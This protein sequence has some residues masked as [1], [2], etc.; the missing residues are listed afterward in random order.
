MDLAFSKQQNQKQ[1]YKEHKFIFCKTYVEGFDSLVSLYKSLQS[2]F[3]HN[4]VLVKN[5]WYFPYFASCK[6]FSLA[7]AT[8]MLEARF[9]VTVPIFLSL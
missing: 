4:S 9:L 3:L 5:F 2:K 1:K 7:L 6:I 8:R